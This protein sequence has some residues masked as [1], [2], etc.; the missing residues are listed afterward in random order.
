MARLPDVIKSDVIAN[1]PA[2]GNEG[3]LF[4]STDETPPTLYRDNGSSWDAI[5]DLGGGATYPTHATLWWDEMTV[6]SG[7]AMVTPVTNGDA[8]YFFATYQDAA[9]NGDTLEQK[10]FLAEGT[11]TL[12]VLG[13]KSTNR[14][15]IDIYIDGVA[16]VSGQDWYN[17]SAQVALL[18][19]GGIAVSGDGVHTLR[20]VVNGKNGSS[21][22]YY[23]ALQ[24]IFLK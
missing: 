8:V 14:A 2:A 21:S 3:N 22:N 7:N 4:A 23:V 17:G 9:A 5:A 12:G 16:V 10:F 19:T 18:T 11:Y 15:K 20:T 13:L 6:I 24:K 1:I